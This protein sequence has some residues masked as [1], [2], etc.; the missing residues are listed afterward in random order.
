MHIIRF[1][2]LFI[3]IF[4]TTASAS[5]DQGTL[6]FNNEDY[7]KAHRLLYVHALEDNK[8]AQFIIGKIYMNGLGS[9]EKDVNL[10]VEF[11]KKSINGGNINAALFLSSAYE[12]GE[13]VT[14]D[15][16]KALSYLQDAVELG[17]T[18]KQKDVLRLTTLVEGKTSKNSCNL[19]SKND[20][21]RV[22]DLISCMKKGYIKGDIIKYYKWDF[23][24]NNN[25]NSL[26]NAVK[27][28]IDE[29]SKYYN[30]D[31]VIEFIPLFVMNATEDDLKKWRKLFSDGR[32][33]SEDCIG[34]NDGF[35]QKPLTEPV[36]CILAAESGQQQA[37]Q[38]VIPWW[39]NGEY[40]L[41]LEKEYAEVLRNQLDASSD[42]L[43]VCKTLREIPSDHFQCLKNVAESNEFFVEKIADELFVEVKQIN[44]KKYETFKDGAKDIKFVLSYV[45]YDILEPSDFSKIYLKIFTDPAFTNNNFD[46]DPQI[47]QKLSEAKFDHKRYQE[48]S[49]NN[50]IIALQYIEKYLMADCSAVQYASS[51]FNL[52]KNINSSLYNQAVS[53]C[54]INDAADQFQ[55]VLNSDQNSAI[56]LLEKQFSDEDYDEFCKNSETF[57]KNN[58]QTFYESLPEDLSKGMLQQCNNSLVIKSNFAI[59]NYISGYPNLDLI[60]EDLEYTCE[61]KIAA[62]CGYAAYIFMF[63]KIDA[64]RSLRTGNNPSGKR[65]R[66]YTL[67]LRGCDLGDNASCAVAYDVLT[68][69]QVIGT[70]IQTTEKEYIFNLLSER[71]SDAFLIREN[72]QCLKNFTFGIGKCRDE[73]RVIQKIYDKGG[74][75]YFS[76]SLAQEYLDHKKCN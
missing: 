49:K 47:N 50:S 32:F 22:K 29:D 8:D 42:P 33:K 15:I 75:D 56:N 24:D 34:E 44:S 3:I 39:F 76:K 21:S 73:C 35:V 23:E 16:T 11:I 20:R 68:Q 57:V 19:Y 54:G 37:I 55:T 31:N 59:N 66:A 53:D 71:Y 60:F 46:K 38:T 45:N 13:I 62:S 12:K 14:K 67:A 25:L 1:I 63:E 30:L 2:T 61:E 58:T 64:N 52:L 41:P 10:G 5:V 70:I 17:V 4:S 7:D 43:I 28:I 72:A 27:L 51:D 36:K 48:I 65:S 40:G 26:Y 74:L 18:N 6:S 9:A 69:K